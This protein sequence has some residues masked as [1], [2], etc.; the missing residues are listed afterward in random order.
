VRYVSWSQVELF[1]KCERQYFYEYILGEKRPETPILVIGKAYHTMIESYFTGVGIA[2]LVDDESMEFLKA[3]T[4]IDIAGLQREMRENLMRLKSQFL[5]GLGRPFIVEWKFEDEVLGYRGTIDAAMQRTPVMSPDGEEISTWLEESCVVD[6]KS[7]TSE[8]RRSQRD[9]VYS[10]Q[11]ALYATVAGTRNA[12]FV[13]IPRNLGEPIKARFV[14]YTEEE[15]NHWR[16]WLV[17]VRDAM[18]S[19]G[20]QMQAYHQTERKNPLCSPQWCGHFFKCYPAALGP[21]E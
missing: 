13:E 9:A 18:L 7:L 1:L 16:S 5:D 21:E 17:G 15:L 2:K 6:W 3:K 14:R 11:L 4:T 8:R 10:G 19:R 20:E 12:G